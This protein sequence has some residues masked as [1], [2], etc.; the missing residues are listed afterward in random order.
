MVVHA[1]DDVGNNADNQG[2]VVG[3]WKAQG[4]LQAKQNSRN[5]ISPH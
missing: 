2:I 4:Q 1:T 3:T 5:K